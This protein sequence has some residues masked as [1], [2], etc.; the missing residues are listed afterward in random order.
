MSKKQLTP[1]ISIYGDHAILVDWQVDGFSEAVNDQVHA[2]SAILRESGKYIE[3]VPGYDW[4]VFLTSPLSRWNRPSPTSNLFCRI[5][6]LA[7]G[8]QESSLRFQFIMGAKTGLIWKQFA[9]LQ[10]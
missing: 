5:S 7:S 6:H 8:K 10:S 2:L 3:V 1:K 9:Q 4:S